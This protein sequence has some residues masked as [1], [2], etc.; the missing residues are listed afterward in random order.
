[1]IERLLLNFKKLTY[2][3]LFLNLC[4]VFQKKFAFYAS[5]NRKELKSFNYF[6]H[7]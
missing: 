1:M 6:L 3:I 5:F 7:C 2:E 4:Y